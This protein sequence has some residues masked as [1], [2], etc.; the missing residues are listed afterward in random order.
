MYFTTEHTFTPGFQANQPPWISNFQWCREVFALNALERRSATRWPLV[1]LRYPYESIE[2]STKRIR[3]FIIFN[4]CTTPDCNC[5][6]HRQTWFAVAVLLAILNRTLWKARRSV[7][8][9][10]GII[11]ESMWFFNKFIKTCQSNVTLIDIHLGVLCSDNAVWKKCEMQSSNY[12]TAILHI[13]DKMQ[14]YILS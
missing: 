3:N 12:Y 7:V 6:A 13:L 2:F 5:Q 4:S 10:Q 11:P 14:R 1:S 9:C 8:L